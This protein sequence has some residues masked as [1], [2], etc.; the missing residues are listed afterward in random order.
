MFR[1]TF[2]IVPLFA[3]LVCLCAASPC[4]NAQ[5]LTTLYSFDGTD[6]NHPGP[7][8]IQGGDGKLYGT[9]SFGGAFDYGIVFQITTDGALTTLHSFNAADGAYPSAGL[10]QASDGKLYGTTYQGGATGYGTVFQITTGG[11]F[12]SASAS[13]STNTPTRRGS[14]R[15]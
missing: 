6:G 7:G 9:T 5:A 10:V 14:G 15:R 11:A 12:T 8:L 13:T 2:R 3:A 1:A 4:A